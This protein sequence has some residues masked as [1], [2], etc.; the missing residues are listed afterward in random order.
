MRNL[1]IGSG[2]ES[3]TIDGDESRVI[4]FDP[5]DFNIVARCDEAIKNVSEFMKDFSDTDA[6]GF[7]AAIKDIN[8]K[9]CGQVDYIFGEGAGKAAFGGVSPI[10]A[11]KDGVTLFERFFDAVI[12]IVQERVT[13]NMEAS[14][15]RMAKYT[16]NAK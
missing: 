6:D 12:P 3:F 8:D 10:A 15:A 1:N 2:R 14:K 16:Q 9:I 4:S 7:S 13:A 5:S 11:D